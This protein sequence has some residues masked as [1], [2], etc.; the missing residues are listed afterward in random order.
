MAA[1]FFDIDLTLTDRTGKVPASAI[2]AIKKLKENGHK[3]FIN[4]GRSRVEIQK[5]LL[6]LGFDG[7]IAA[8]GTSIQV[9][10]TQLLEVLIPSVLLTE[11]LPLFEQAQ[12]ALWLEGPEHLYVANT[13]DEDF[14]SPLITYLG[15]QR[16]HVLSWKEQQIQAN[17]IMCLVRTTEALSQ[18]QPLFETHFT[19]LSHRGGLFELIPLGYDK[20]TGM[21]FVL[22]YCN[23]ANEVTYAIGD[24]ANDISMLKKAHHSIVM[25]G[26]DSEVVCVADYETTSVEN[27]GIAR[28]L[29]HYHLI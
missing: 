2:A 17:K 21:D 16:N 11:I 10:Q 6:D 25:G 19:T 28:A 15:L 8:C 13:D 3:A 18:V 20:A 22:E 27:D 9:G 5:D 4:T 14:I 7:V 26:S 12:I 23:L 24:S 29:K 1:V